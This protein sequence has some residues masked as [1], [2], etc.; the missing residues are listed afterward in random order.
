M[1]DKITNVLFLCTGNS[2]RSIM[3][4][5]LMDRLGG[6]RFKGYSAGSHPTG[7][8]NV[9]ALAL[10]QS[11][12]FDTGFAAS[13]SWDEFASPGAPVMDFVITVCSDA[14]AKTCPVWPGHPSSAHWGI[15]DP[16]DAAGSEDEIRIAFQNAFDRLAKAIANFRKIPLSAMDADQL[17]ARLADIGRRI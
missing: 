1:S 7:Q 13:K 8:V 14:A 6:G 4:E 10:L 2:A 15:P 16:A 11:H 12:S 17:A 5:A 9:H 3:A